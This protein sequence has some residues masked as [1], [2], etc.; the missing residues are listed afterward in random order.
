MD[1][2][3]K[4]HPDL[5]FLD[6]VLPDMNGNQVLQQLKADPDT[7][8]IPIAILSNFNQDTLVQNA[9]KMSATDYILKYQISPTDLVAKTHALLEEA[10]AQTP[11]PIQELP[12]VAPTAPTPVAMSSQVSATTNDPTTPQVPPTPP[13]AQD[14]SLSDEKAVN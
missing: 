7:K 4:E 2:A 6:Q 5:I 9:M 8:S 10:H 13:P 12:Q 14:T 1:K 11:A 3:K